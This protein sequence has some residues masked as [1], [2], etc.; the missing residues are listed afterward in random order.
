[1]K[2]F[3]KRGVAVAVM[4]LCILASIAWG[5]HKKPAVEVLDGGAALDETLPTAHFARYIADEAGVLSGKTEN[6]VALYDANWDEMAGSILAV[7][8]VETADADVEDA[9]YDW[10]YELNLSEDDGILLL[11]TGTK[12]Y[13]LVASGGFYDLLDALSD[14]YVDGMLYEG[15]A[16]EVV[17]P[18]Q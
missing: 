16:I 1:M 17:D 2:F 6:A 13:R 15:D 9:A 3:Q 5:Q 8:T 11:V 14:S 4:L 18:G 7:V 12:D 10:A